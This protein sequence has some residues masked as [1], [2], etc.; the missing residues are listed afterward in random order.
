MNTLSS[1]A[2]SL[3]RPMFV[4]SGLQAR[5][6]LPTGKGACYSDAYF[7]FLRKLVHLR[8]LNVSED[9]LH[10]L[11]Q[12]E[13]KLLSLLHVDSI[14]SPT[15]FLDSC[16]LSKNAQRRLLLSHY[17]MGIDLSSQVLQLGLNFS[18]AAPELFDGKEMGEDAL[19]VLG[20]YLKLVSRIQAQVCAEI[21]VIRDALRWAGR[22]KP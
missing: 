6:E 15:W 13:K 22:V 1:I 8:T 12:L 9:T 18:D 19:R 16:G 5:F 2:K 17:D 7:A 3:N 21:P 4:I 11:W 20:Q 10:K 14:G